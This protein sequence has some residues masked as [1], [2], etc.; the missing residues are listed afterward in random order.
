M[1]TYSKSRIAAMLLAISAFVPAS[2]AQTYPSNPVRI[3]V[4]Q[5]PGGSQDAMARLIADGLSR[6]LGQQF[7]VENK[8]GANGV[9]GESQ[10]AKTKADG[11]TLMFNISSLVTNTLIYDN[12]SYTMK[13]FDPVAMMAKASFLLV[14]NPSFQASTLA[15]LTKLAGAKSVDFA[16]PG[17]GSLHHLVM[18]VL[19]K[20]A[21]I[22]MT[23]IPYKSGAPALM[24]VVGG[25]VP[26]MFATPAIALPFIKS[27]K[28]KAIA[29]TSRTRLN[30]LP[31]VPTFEE[32][33]LP[34][35]E[36]DVWFGLFAPAGTPPQIVNKLNAEIRAFEKT[37]EFIKMA[38][39]LGLSIVDI[40]PKDFAVAIDND[41]K[42]FGPIIKA[43]NFTP[44]K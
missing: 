40:T 41:L 14:A 32:S 24:D 31:E 12:I 21:N 16:S 13:S 22:K 28:L 25:Q 30:V 6:K 27:G 37:P 2:Y 17:P 39:E 15:D 36:A 18:E 11:Y 9:I 42:M 1:N 43:H 10:F 34:G 26:M 29:V 7:F 4:A 23:H 20:R 8:P 33:G 35:F 3:V 19:M 5:A 38:S 44:D